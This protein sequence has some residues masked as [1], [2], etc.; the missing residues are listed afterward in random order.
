MPD[1]DSAKVPK[2]FLSFASEDGYGVNWFTRK[3]WFGVALGNVI[4]ENYLVNER[5]DF[6]PLRSW[7]EQQIDEATVVI[8]FV[9]EYYRNQEWTGVEWN[10][11]L[12]EFHRRRLI[13]VPIMLDAHA[14]AWWDDLLHKGGLSG[15]SPDYMYSDF[16]DGLG[17]RVDISGSSS[18]QMKI[19]KL[20]LRIKGFLSAP[21][22]HG[23]IV[24][25][26]V[27]ADPPVSGAGSAAPLTH[28]PSPVG[29]PTGP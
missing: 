22:D 19:Q 2:I 4:V 24:D 7:L 3:D 25:P 14:K 29:P 17:A 15:L 8:A 16:T 10:K 13:F 1:R 20:A 27:L 9:S 6:G 12:T 18:V 11:A 28:T 5:L 23:R 26:P 21:S